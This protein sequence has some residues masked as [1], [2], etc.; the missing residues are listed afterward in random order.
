MHLAL[1]IQ[2]N[3]VLRYLPALLQNARKIETIGG[4]RSWRY[5]ETTDGGVE[6]FIEGPILGVGRQYFKVNELIPQT[7]SLVDTSKSTLRP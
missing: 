3:S 4:E 7:R 1:D 6:I 2:E 5:V